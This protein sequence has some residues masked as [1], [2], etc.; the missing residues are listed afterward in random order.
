MDVK[1]TQA[2]HLEDNDDS[3]PTNLFDDPPDFYPPTP[4]PT[5]QSFS[6][7]NPPLTLEL[8]LVGSSPLEAHRL[9][10]GSRVLARY[11]EDHPDLVAG[12]TVLELGAGAGLPSL[13]AA[14]CRARKAVVT[15]YPDPDLVANM[16]DNIRACE[17]V[18]NGFESG[19]LPDGALVAEGYVWGADV[20]PLLEHMPPESK[21]GFDVLILA[22]LLFRHSE[23]GKL[24]HTISTALRRDADAMALVFFT[25]YRPWLRHKDLRFF[26][27]AREAGFVVEHVLEEKLDQPMFQDDPGDLDVRRTCSGYVVRWPR[28]AMQ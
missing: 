24:V 2:V 13:V 10:T 12:K 8:G 1:L 14:I 6:L 26:D 20:K 19:R 21:E 18:V 27:T 22:D 9:W 28:T 17:R 16:W 11:F 7:R 5:S 25:S 23:H 15:D 3:L 4:P